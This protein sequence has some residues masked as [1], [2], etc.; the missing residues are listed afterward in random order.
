MAMRLSMPRRRP[1]DVPSLTVIAEAVDRD[2]HGL[3]DGDCHCRSFRFLPG[4]NL[5][6]DIATSIGM[7]RS[8][9]MSVWYGISRFL[10]HSTSRMALPRKLILLPRLA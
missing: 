10:A 4:R 5:P 9:F 8:R 7:L 6:L 2:R 3:E 1:M